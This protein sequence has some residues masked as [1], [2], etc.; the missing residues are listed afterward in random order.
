MK[1]S[2]TVT[3]LGST[4]TA[5]AP[6]TGLRATLRQRTLPWRLSRPAGAALILGA[7]GVVYRLLMML[8]SAPA[9]H[10]DEATMGL[11]ALHISE[12]RELPVFFYGQHYM[13]TLEAYLAAPLFALFGPSVLALRIPTLALYAGFLV[14][15]YLLTRRLFSPWWAVAAVGFFALGSDRLVRNQLMA[16]GGYPE[17]NALGVSLIL[18]A[19]L[20]VWPGRFPTRRWIAFGGWGLL[21]GITLWD[22]WLVGPYLAAA[23]VLLVVF[24]WRDLLRLPGLT[25]LV[26]VLVGAAPL[27]IH[28]LTAAPG[29]G[30]IEAFLNLNQGATSGTLADH[31]VSGVLLGVPMATGLCGVNQC[32]PLQYGWGAVYPVLLVVGVVIAVRGLR[33]PEVTAVD[34]VKHATTLALMFAAGLSVLAYARSGAPVLDP[35]AGSRYLHCLLISLPALLWPVWRAAR[36]HWPRLRGILAATGLVVLVAMA[37][38]A[39]VT[40][41]AY[42]DTD[43]RTQRGQE[44][45]IATLT[46]LDATHVYGEYWTCNRLTFLSEERIVCAV[47]ADDLS[48]GFDRYKPY[49]SAVDDSSRPA[50][51]FPAGSEIDRRFAAS[52][53]KRSVTPEITDAGGFRIYQLPPA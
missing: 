41:V 50:Y 40:R 23:G 22:D 7:A 35:P 45:L 9:I 53:S 31:V 3:A 13:G 14:L 52:L 36:D 28:D 19:V 33:R 2:A 6:T 17:I 39:T 46:R 18:L 21:A 12:G 29:E 27:I 4:R 30:S 25:M 34:R 37:G 42:V 49:R 32:G 24:C 5:P 15:T 1:E 51:V 16:G 26:G 47:V 20:I 44:A 8:S 38:W 43:V 11:A 10:S 48:A